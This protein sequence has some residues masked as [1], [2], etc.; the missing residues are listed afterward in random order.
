M[1]CD[2]SRTAFSM[3]GIS[4]RNSWYG[5]K[6]ICFSA[7]K[8]GKRSLL[9]KNLTGTSTLTQ[10]VMFCASRNLYCFLT[11]RSRKDVFLIEIR[12]FAEFVMFHSPCFSR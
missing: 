10:G 9:S 5:W 12:L 3:A 4:Y 8:A 1:L 6:T 7:Q 2:N 11:F